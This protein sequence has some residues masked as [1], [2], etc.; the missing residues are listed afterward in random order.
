MWAIPC[1]MNTEIAIF[2]PT[3]SNSVKFGELVDLA[4]IRMSDKF[5]IFILSILFVTG[6]QI[7]HKKS[8]FSAKK[9]FRNC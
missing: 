9:F 7:S 6:I 1:H 3:S 5:Q 4:G 2:H 8:P